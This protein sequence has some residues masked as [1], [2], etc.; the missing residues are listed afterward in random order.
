MALLSAQR[1][2]V[3]LAPALPI[4]LTP[5]DQHRLVLRQGQFTL[6]A[7]APSVGKSVVARNVVV[8]TRD[9][10]SLYFSADSD[11]YTVKTTVMGMLTGEAM[12]E[13][14]KKLTSDAWEHY[15]QQQLHSAD[16]VDWCFSPE[17][18]LDFIANRMKAHTEMY[19]EFPKLAVVDNIGDMVTEGEEEYAELR[20]ICRELRKMARYTDA[21]IIGLVHVK[22]AFE[23]GQKAVTMGSLLGNLAKTPENVLGLNW[24]DPTC[25]RVQM[26]VAKARGAKRGA[27]IPLDLNYDNATVGGFYV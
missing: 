10:R 24:T 18:N 27:V 25:S 6:L 8:N 26:I 3:T 14:E 13:I 5:F 23:D 2:S 7:S 16:H 12:A 15:Y 1:K 9:I 22:G 21:H 11:E 17:I 4:R 20:S 19:G